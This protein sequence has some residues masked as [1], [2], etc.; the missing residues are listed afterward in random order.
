M[1]NLKKRIFVGYSE[2][3]K[4]YKLYNLIIKKFVIS[5]DVKFD[6]E[7]AWD[8][9]AN[10]PKDKSIYVDL[11]DEKQIQHDDEEIY[12]PPYSSHFSSSF[13]TPPRL[14]YSRLHR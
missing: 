13:S 14:C 10:D 8:W 2:C 5:R 3:S 11:E 6:K 7:A 4:T 9:S 12:T 1:T